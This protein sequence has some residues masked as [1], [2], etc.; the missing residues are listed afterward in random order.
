MAQMRASR[1]V[2]SA[3]PGPEAAPPLAAAATS[4]MA[5]PIRARRS[6]VEHTLE[7]IGQRDHDRDGFR[8]LRTAPGAPA[9]AR[10]VPS[11]RAAWAP[12][13]TSGPPLIHPHP[14]VRTP[15]ARRGFRQPSFAVP[16]AVRGG[17]PEPAPA[18]GVWLTAAYSTVD[19]FAGNVDGEA[20]ESFFLRTARGRHQ[21]R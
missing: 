17:S 12:P 5:S 21:R 4:S 2:R 9:P 7:T 10:A 18:P 19:N 1:A 6:S 15:P 13:Y 20:A 16:G 14:V 3:T 8:P 11:V